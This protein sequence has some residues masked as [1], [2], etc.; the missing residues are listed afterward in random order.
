MKKIDDTVK[1]E[2]VY[3]AKW[4]MILSCILQAVFLIIGKWSLSV[5]FANLITGSVAVFNFLL[6]GITVQKAVDMEQK[7][8]A[9][10][11]RFSQSIRLLMQL[12]FCALGVV[13]LDPA[14]AI[15][16]LFFPRV[17]VSVRIIF[18]KNQENN[19][20]SDDLSQG[21]DTD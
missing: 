16:P 2:T 7:D 17:G 14:A 20:S 13:F 12:A 5:L 3:I 18:N 10:L 9:N 11:I 8:A 15:I 6:M 21:G 4:T 1:K 19:S